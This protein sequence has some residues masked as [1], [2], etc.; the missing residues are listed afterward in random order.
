MN[1]LENIQEMNIQ[2]F[3]AASREY[4]ALDDKPG[5][6]EDDVEEKKEN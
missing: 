2:A 5:A 6:V 1:H 4:F 3:I